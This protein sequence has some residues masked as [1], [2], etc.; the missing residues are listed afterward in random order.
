MASQDK[1]DELREKLT[2][3]TT[4]RFNQDFQAAFRNY[5][6]NGDGVIDADELRTLLA[7]AGIGT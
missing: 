2:T 5:D 7:D 1:K 6:L 3:L 4:E